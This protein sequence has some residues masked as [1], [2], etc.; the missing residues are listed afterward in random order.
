MAEELTERQRELVAD[1]TRLW[2]AGEM[3]L[4]PLAAHY[5]SVIARIAS[6]ETQVDVLW[7]DQ[8]LGGP[9]GE[10]KSAWQYLADT[11]VDLLRESAESLEATGDVLVMAAREYQEA[12]RINTEAIAEQKE[13]IVRAGSRETTTSSEASDGTP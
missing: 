11:T 10:A 2:E 12:E 6:A 4:K 9:F 13:N 8:L 1:C 5:R 7:R 3:K